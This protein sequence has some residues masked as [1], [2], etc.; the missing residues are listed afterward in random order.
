[1]NIK[2]LAKILNVSSSTVSRVLNE[3][4]G[5]SQETRKMVLNGIKKYNYVPSS[6]ARNLSSNSTKNIA[7]IVPDI[8]NQ[9]FSDLMSGVA[10][11][12]AKNNYNIFYLGTNELESIEHKALDTM[13]SERLAGLIIAPVNSNDT[14][15]LNKLT[16]LEKVNV[17]VVLVDREFKAKSF[18]GVFV[19]NVSGAKEATKCLI[20][21]GHD[22]IAIITG[23]EESKPGSER[24]LG[25]LKAFKEKNLEI[26]SE[27]IVSGDFKVRRAYQMTKE[28]MSLKNKPTAIF[29]SNNLT[30]LGCIKY[31]TEKNIKIGEDVSI[32]GFDDLKTLEYIGFNF[33]AVYRDAKLQGEKA[34]E[35]VIE[36][37]KT[38]NNI[39][40]KINVPYKLILR[41]SE[42]FNFSKQKN[43]S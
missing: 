25:Y 35:L 33:S 29:C 8:E 7:V 34:M 32:I 14:V 17:P 36:K 23:P 37:L 39:V 9:F 30:S 42:K 22:R 13:S 16:R 11:V 21:N 3:A 27:L 20:E 15:T 31:L 18:S 38:K 40:K 28:L 2:E 1:M 6:V 10:S 43:K 26:D 24:L 12:A 4:S 19:D 5:V 41:G